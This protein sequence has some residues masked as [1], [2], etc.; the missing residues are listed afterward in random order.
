[1]AAALF[2]L[3]AGNWL[4]KQWMERLPGLDCL[5]S[6]PGFWEMYIRG[7]SWTGQIDGWNDQYRRLELRVQI[8]DLFQK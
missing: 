4:G 8:E 3:T 5:L 1:M 2:G 6:T 7:N